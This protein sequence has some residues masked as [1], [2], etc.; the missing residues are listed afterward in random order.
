MEQSKEKDIRPDLWGTVNTARR[1]ERTSERDNGERRERNF[2]R[3]KDTYRERPAKFSNRRDYRPSTEATDRQDRTERSERKVLVKRDSHTD[4]PRRPR[5]FRPRGEETTGN[6]HSNYNR[7]FDRDR[8]KISGREKEGLR[9]KHYSKKK[10]LAHRLKNED[11]NAE[12]RLN[13]YISM[14]GVCS[15]RD[16]DELIVAGRVK[17]NGEVVQYRRFESTEERQGGGGRRSDFPRKE[18]ISRFK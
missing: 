5:I 10:L 17:V 15:R 9:Q 11:E 6:N 12:L 7:P 4:N 8:K 14:G 1:F 16:A 3:E 13:R 2:N 18:S